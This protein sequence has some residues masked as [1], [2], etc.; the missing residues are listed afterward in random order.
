ME[1]R[2]LGHTGLNISPLVLGTV[3]FSWL[4]NE[5]DSFEVLDYAM[6]VGLNFFDTSNNYNAGKSEELLGRWFARGGGRREHTVL[7]TKVYSKPNEWSSPDPAK[8]DGSWV[9]P[10]DSGLSARHIRAA[11]EALSGELPCC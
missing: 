9:G 5:A 6:E 2:K 1:Y 8:R 3:N 4:T 11:V 7:A 10:N